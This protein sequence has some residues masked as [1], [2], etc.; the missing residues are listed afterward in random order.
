[1]KVVVLTF[2]L[3]FIWSRET[4]LQYPG[5]TWVAMGA[6]REISELTALYVND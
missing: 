6:S 3:T 5:E 2:Y 1:M 4:S